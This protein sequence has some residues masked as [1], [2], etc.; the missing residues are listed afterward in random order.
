MSSIQAIRTEGG[1]PTYPEEGGV[2]GEV[3]WTCLPARERPKTAILVALLLVAVWVGIQLSWGEWYLTGLAILILWGSLA[4]FYLP[5]RYVMDEER[6]VVQALLTRTEKPWSRYRR[7][8][9]DMRGVLISPYERRSRL[10]R[11]HG[12]NLRFEGKDRERVLEFIERKVPLE[13]MDGR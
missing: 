13:R 4:S 5:T 2:G 7:A 10:D 9:A 8:A 6:I 1:H 12:L 3:R 11:F